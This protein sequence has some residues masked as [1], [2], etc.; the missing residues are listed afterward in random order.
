MPEVEFT[1]REINTM[2]SSIKTQLDEHGK[3]HTDILGKVGEVKTEILSKVGEVHTEAKNTNG[4]VADINR[5]REQVNG[6][7]K[8]AAFFAAVIIFPILGWAIY[9]LSSIDTKIADSVEDTL[10]NYEIQP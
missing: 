2:F 8:V 5:W 6:G 7:A 3:V 1:N 4:K 10:S 9:V